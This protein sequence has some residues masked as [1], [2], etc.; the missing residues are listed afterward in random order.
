MKK[1]IFAATITG[2][3]FMANFANAQKDAA[4][5]KQQKEEAKKEKPAKHA[6]KPV[7]KDADAK[8]ATAEPKEK[9]AGPD[10]ITK[11]SDDAVKTKKAGPNKITKKDD[12]KPTNTPK[13]A[14]EKK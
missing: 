5:P 4:A 2:A 3:L 10:K 8:A 9:K 7:K 14:A 13:P 1:I 6:P 12:S 11:K